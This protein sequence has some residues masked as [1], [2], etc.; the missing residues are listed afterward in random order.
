M[1]CAVV[2]RAGKNCAIRNNPVLAQVLQR[3]SIYTSGMKHTLTTPFST[4]Q[5]MEKPRY[6]LYFYSDKGLSHV[7]AHRHDFYELIFYLSGRI[8][9]KIAE[10]EYLCSAGDA[11][12]IPPGFV[13]ENFID[14][15]VKYERFVLWLSNDYVDSLCAKSSDFKQMFDAMEHSAQYIKNFEFSIFSVFCNLFT[16]I[17]EE[18]V[19]NQFGSKDIRDNT[20]EVLLLTW[21]RHFFD[22]T[23]PARPQRQDVLISGMLAYIEDNLSSNLSLDALAQRFFVSKYHLSHLFRTAMGTTIHKYVL[24]KRLAAATAALLGGS[25]LNQIAIDCGFEEYSSFYRAFCREYGMS[26]SKWRSSQMQNFSRLD[27]LQ[28][29]IDQAGVQQAGQDEQTV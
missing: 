19:R 12:M 5:V 20:L 2:L 15:N 3:I 11:A 7:E 21:S 27:R 9:M 6:E 28:N 25:D 16:T 23:K 17:L 24:K 29:Q 13:H 22:F 26:P 4:R 1:H 14:P 8:R 10:R 18:Q